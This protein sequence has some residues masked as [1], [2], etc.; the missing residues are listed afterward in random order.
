MFGIQR[1]RQIAVTADGPLHQLGKERHK[2]RKLSQAAFRFYLALVHINKISH[3]L[4]CIKG[5][6]HGNHQIHKG[7]R[8]FTAKGMQDAVY[9]GYGKVGVLYH[10]QNA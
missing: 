1:L 8:L 4:E 5:N 10:R 7:Q 6:A 9:I 3:G 2:E